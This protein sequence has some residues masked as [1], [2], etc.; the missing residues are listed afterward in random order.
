MRGQPLSTVIEG[1]PHACTATILAPA[2]AETICR[3]EIIPVD[4][5]KYTVPIISTESTVAAPIENLAFLI[6]P[7]LVLEP[8]SIPNASERLDIITAYSQTRN[9]AGSL[10]M[11]ICTVESATAEYNVTISGDTITTIGSPT[12]IGLANN[13]EVRMHY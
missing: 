5:Y 10:N 1:C 2:L 13:T 3:S 6:Q 7:V 12:I 11:T 4:Y 9:C 8:S